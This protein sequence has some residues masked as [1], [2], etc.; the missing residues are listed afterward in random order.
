MESLDED[1]DLLAL[2]PKQKAAAVKL[3]QTGGDIATNTVDKLANEPLGDLA[4]LNTNLD[5]YRLAT[6]NSLVTHIRSRL[7]FIETFE[8]AVHDDDTYERRG[9]DSIHNLLRQNIWLVDPTYQV[10]QDD[11]TLKKIIAENWDKEFSGDEAVQRP[12]FLCMTERRDSDLLVLIEIKRP[13]VKI[14]V[15]KIEQVMRYKYILTKYSEKDYRDFR[16]HLIGREINPLVKTVDLAKAG[17][18]TKTYT[19]F[20]GDARRYYQDYLTMVEEN[21]KAV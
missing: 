8:K 12:D 2:T 10:L 9:A 16:C 13:S 6:I 18:N 1:A 17:I 11:V 15:D 4:N 7:S 20:I 3:L 19:D 5:I 21:P 14:T